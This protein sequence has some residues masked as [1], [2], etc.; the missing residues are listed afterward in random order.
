M[1]NQNLFLKQ[2]G[3]SEEVQKHFANFGKEHAIKKG[4][5]L[6]KQGVICN[7]IGIVIEG[8]FKIYHE[9]DGKEMSI[10]LRYEGFI[11]EYSSFITQLPS[12]VNIVAFSD[13]KIIYLSKEEIETFFSFN[14]ETQ[15]FG[16]SIAENQMVMNQN[17]LFSI[18]YDTAEQRYN[19][20]I[21]QYPKLFQLFPLKDIANCIGITPET[22]SRIRTKKLHS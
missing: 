4:Q 13:C 5:L 2:M 15:K 22:L 3:F 19:K 6:L 20:L 12:E 18:L 11:T 9:L 10:G 8:L 1:S 16:R 14:M 17:M 7:F 21:K